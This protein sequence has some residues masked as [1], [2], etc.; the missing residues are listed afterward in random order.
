MTKKPD[1]DLR[2]DQCNWNLDGEFHIV[3]GP[4]IVLRRLVL[5]LEQRAAA[6]RAVGGE[7]AR[8]RAVRRG[9]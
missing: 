1:G 7:R 6:K 9:G 3:V 8:G 2:T 4:R 5:C